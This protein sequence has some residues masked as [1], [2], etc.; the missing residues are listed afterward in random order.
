M[1]TYIFSIPKEMIFI[2]SIITYASSH[3]T[4]NSTIGDH[5]IHK[6][7]TRLNTIEKQYICGLLVT[8]NKKEAISGSPSGKPSSIGDLFHHFNPTWISYS[9]SVES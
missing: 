9:Y 3:C 5:I 2:P 1:L 6:A 8:A 4:S 7:C